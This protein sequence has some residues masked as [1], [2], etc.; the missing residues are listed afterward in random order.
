VAKLP[1]C[2]VCGEKLESLFSQSDE[3]LAQCNNDACDLCHEPLPDEFWR[4]VWKRMRP[5]VGREKRYGDALR[6][7]RFIGQ[8]K[9][10]VWSQEKKLG[11]V[12]KI[13]SDALKGD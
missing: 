1:P 10:K 11:R 2:V 5:D 6:K 4:T 9:S 8:T 12:G 3:A 7:C 13:A